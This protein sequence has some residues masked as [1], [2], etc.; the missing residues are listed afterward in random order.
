MIDFAGEIYARQE[1]QS[2][3]LGT[4]EQDNKPWSVHETPWDFV[5]QLLDHDLDRIAPEL[6]RASRTSRTSARPASSA[7]STARSRSAP[8]ATR[9]S[10]R[11]AA[12]AACGSPAR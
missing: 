8:T 7:S 1:G 2:M 5:F 9:W 10:A 12:C 4:Y 3:L 6:E 11:S